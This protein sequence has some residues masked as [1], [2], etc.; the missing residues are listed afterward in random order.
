[1]KDKA[2]A[3]RFAS[4]VRSLV[5]RE[6]TVAVVSGP[7]W[8]GEYAVEISRSTGDNRRWTAT[9]DAEVGATAFVRDHFRRCL[10]K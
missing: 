8:G 4:E 3:E 5:D 6:D 9:A 2:R 10:A 7:T 1:M